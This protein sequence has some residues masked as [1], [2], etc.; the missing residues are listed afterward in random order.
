MNLHYKNIFIKLL[1]FFILMFLIGLPIN[2]TFEFYILLLFIPV[3]IFSKISLKKRSLYFLLVLILFFSIIKS[4]FLNINLQEGH[5][6]VLL[7]KNSSTFYKK[8][9]PYEIYNFFNNEF[10]I[11]YSDSKCNEELGRCW[12]N[13][14]PNRTNSNSSPTNSIFTTSSDWSFQNIKY[15]RIVNNIN[16]SNLKSAK[17]GAVNN[18]DYNFFWEDNT[19]I[20]RDNIPFFVMYEISKELIDSSLCWKGNLFWEKNNNSYSKK[21]N[22]NYEC[23]KISNLDVGK[24]IYGTSMGTKNE[25]ILKLEKGTKLKSKEI[26]NLVF[27][28]FLIISITYSF[29]KFNYK[30]FCMSFISCIGFILVVF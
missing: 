30:L 26:F 20:H 9:L 10:K 19:D 17:I 28:L 16:I 24:K 7:N 5:N 2:N 13:F 15:S 23:S 8:N 25:L 4:A 21:L 3:I 18:L 22:T 6:L 14:D 27:V 11:Y 29:L 1:V 12:K